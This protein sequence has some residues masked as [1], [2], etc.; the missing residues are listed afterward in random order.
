MRNDRV[1]IPFWH[2]AH[3]AQCFSSCIY[4]YFHRQ[5]SYNFILLQKCHRL[6]C[7]SLKYRDRAVGS[8]ENGSSL[9]LIHNLL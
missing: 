4:T 2:V 9:R 1:L 3:D 7:M 5:L 6:G 8:I